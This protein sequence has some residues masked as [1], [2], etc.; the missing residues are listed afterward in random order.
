MRYKVNINRPKLSPQEIARYRNFS[1][2]MAR[3]SKTGKPF[4]RK[5]WFYGN[6][7]I[8]VFAVA[9]ILIY[10]DK[11]QQNETAQ[12][13]SVDSATVN[14]TASAPAAFV[15]PPLQDIN[16]NYASYIINNKK[17]GELAYNKSKIII[18][19]NALVDENN[20]LVEGDVELRYREFH[21]VVDFFVSGIPMTYD[22]AGNTYHFDSAGMMEIL[23][24][25]DGKP[26]FIHPDK[27][28]EIR[29][30]SNY[31]GSQY[32]L[33][34]LDTAAK[35]WE[36]RGKDD[37]VEGVQ[38]TQPISSVPAIKDT[39]ASEE[40]I[41]QK[42][43]M[44]QMRKDCEKVKNEIAEIS[45]TKP[46]E[47]KKLNKKKYTFNI[48]VDP[49]EFPELALYKNVQFEVGEENKNFSSKMYKT[50]WESA[51]LS[52]KE[53]GISYNLSLT[54]GSEKHSFV[55]YPVFEGKS[56]ED[57]MKTFK[58]KFEQYQVK[59]QE[60]QEQER[61]LREEYE[62]KLKQMKEEAAARQKQYEEQM[63][64]WKEEQ[65]SRE[66][67]A[68]TEDEVLRVFY[69]NRFGVYN[70]DSPQMYP[71][72]E[73][74]AAEFS[75]KDGAR[76]NTSRVYLAEKNRNAMFTYYAGSGSAYERFKYNPS[77]KNMCWTI[78]LDNKLAVYNYEDFAAIPKNPGQHNFRM[79]LSEHE[80]KSLE[81][82]KSFL[83]I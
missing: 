36:C 7:F 60:R 39:I 20:N 81:E 37:V 3:Y 29:M 63:K 49:K 11:P 75:N 21:D 53:K 31:P 66:K 48:E 26:V 10:L 14:N 30:A 64:R 24:Y 16:V 19:P 27:K 74:I 67:V 2:V 17:G 41:E 13:K 45:K 65:A 44:V 32:N 82:L 46:V 61:K 38:K 18:P 57:A 73:M 43:V 76:I 22:S 71:K 23:A 56:Y 4:F 58:G 69:A 1:G 35:N 5:P 54:K 28:I 50:T 12:E 62:A 42:P 72:G 6:V 8:A 40:S 33:Y 47:P 80:F 68:K 78:T 15:N 34:Y 59:L 51:A 70:C 77:A 52:E 83:N 55:V 25:K 79:K 9:V